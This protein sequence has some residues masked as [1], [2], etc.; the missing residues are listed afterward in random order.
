[1]TKTRTN[2][3]VD[4]DEIQK[5][6]QQT[7]KHSRTNK[8]SKWNI[9]KEDR[10][11]HS[12]DEAVLAVHSWVPGDHS[13]RDRAEATVHC[14]LVAERDVEE[15]EDRRRAADAY[16]ADSLLVVRSRVV[17]VDC[18]REDSA[19]AAVADAAAVVV[20]GEGNVD[21]L[22]EE[23]EEVVA[24]LADSNTYGEELNVSS[25]SRASVSV[26]WWLGW[27]TIDYY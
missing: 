3:S 21:R 15:V 12:G 13:H 16:Q 26:G 23:E 18:R 25:R 19:V 7:N 14:I 24:S 20:E 27:V 4:K 6:N 22:D 10:G 1:M 5:P 17:D 8:Q 9:K 2:T 11:D